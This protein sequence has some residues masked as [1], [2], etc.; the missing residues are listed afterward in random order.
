VVHV[1]DLQQQAHGGRERDALVAGERQ[2]LVVVLKKGV[3]CRRGGDASAM[4]QR[5]EVAGRAAA[6]LQALPSS[7]AGAVIMGCWL[8]NKLVATWDNP[9]RNQHTIYLMRSQ[10][11]LCRQASFFSFFLHLLQA[12]SP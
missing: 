12:A 4:P 8:S 6:L 1:V 2:H 7:L 11:G 3:G 5:G 9:K 10:H